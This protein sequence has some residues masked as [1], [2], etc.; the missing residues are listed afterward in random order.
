MNDKLN[1]IPNK[2][3]LILGLEDIRLFKNNNT[4]YY[5]ATTL[6]YSYNDTIRI[7]KGEYN[8]ETKELKNN[9]CMIP[10]T[11]T[12][13]E[14]NWIQ[15]DDKFIYRW[16]PLELGV[17]KDNKLEITH[18]IETPVFFNKYR[19]STNAFEY[20]NEFWFVTHGIMDCTP[21]KYFHQIVILNKD[22]KLVKYTVPFY[23]DKL[24]I[25]YCLGFIIINETIYMTSSR[26]D[27]N[28]IIVKLNL[29][30]L[31]KYFM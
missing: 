31:D 7:V 17:M 16:H 3:S 21:R 29:K 8:P 23:F 20:N 28:P 13:C 10:P 5:T 2:D 11:E 15:V 27:C 12:D 4:I 26:N 9:I 14:K 1:D 24:A 6:E 22:Y 19:G 18:T 30:D 25:E